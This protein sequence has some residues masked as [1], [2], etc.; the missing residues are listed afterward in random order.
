MTRRTT[1]TLAVLVAL[2][3]A[4]CGG[5]GSSSTPST[6]APATSAAAPATSAAAPTTAPETTEGATTATGT[7][8]TPNYASGAYRARRLAEFDR[9]VWVGSPPGDDRVFVVEQHE[10]RIRV[11]GQREPFL[12]LPEPVTTGE[13]QGLLGLAFHPDFAQ[14]GRYFVNFTN[15]EGDTRVQEFH[16]GDA[17]PVKTWL[18]VDQP[19][20]NHNGGNLVFGPDGRLYIGMGDG[21][22][23]GDPQNHA[24]DRSSL[25][26]KLLAIDVDKGSGK[27]D[28]VAIGVRNP[29]R[30][31][32]APDGKSIWI[33]DV[34]QNQWEEIDHT[35]F[36]MPSDA[37]FGWRLFEGTHPYEGDGEKP[38]GY[39]GPVFEYS[40]D[41]GCSVTG[42]VQLP[43]DAYLFGDYC[44]AKYWVTVGNDTK[45]AKLDI[46][47]PVHFGLD[48]GGRLLVASGDGGIYL[49][50]PEAAA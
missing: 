17:K 46:P 6:T 14:N 1:V 45:P 8:T 24:Q 41:D 33:G 49:V 25:L 40:H 30:F 18:E 28:I 50:T 20:P 37:N 48:N 4:A 35:P 15:A 9:P 11:L 26:G 5:G 34:G 32:F 12:T 36:P 38:K 2:A 22:S 31:S 39:I 29:W 7:A 23:A 16:A 19:Y 47:A 10:A 27:P 13:E 3:A 21:G 43:G 42:G 44:S